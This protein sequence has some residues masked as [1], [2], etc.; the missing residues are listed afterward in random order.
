VEVREAAYR[1]CEKTGAALTATITEVCWLKLAKGV[2]WLGRHRDDESTSDPGLDLLSAAAHFNLISLAQ[3]LLAEGHCPTSDT[4]L[5]PPPIQVAAAAGHA[6]MVELFQRHLPEFEEVIE[7]PPYW[8]GKTGPSSVFG[9]AIRGDMDILRLAMYP[10]SRANSDSTDFAGYR[11]GTIPRASSVG[12]ALARAQRVTRNLEVF[13]YIGGFFDK[14]LSMVGLHDSLVACSREGKLSI[15]RHLLDMGV[16]VHLP[17]GYTFRYLRTG[18]PPLVQ[19]CIGC[20]EDIVDL[21]LERG[22]NPN[23]GANKSLPRTA[24]PM[25]AS[26]GSLSIV[27]KLLDH[28]AQINEAQNSWQ[29][30]PAV[31]YAIAKEHTAMI[32]C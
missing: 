19:A 15:V 30:R 24:L 3:E 26:S 6:D 10:P 21:L 7:W 11:Y 22:A 23:Y 8:H 5:F 2:D 9:A 27:R 31:W 28:G 14:P 4:R 16:P 32:T 29:N 13:R 25:A 18:G 1:I 20:H 17:P 12:I